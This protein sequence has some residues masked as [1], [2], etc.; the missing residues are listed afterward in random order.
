LGL[1]QTAFL[2]YNI[3]LINTD[4]DLNK[5]VKAEV[6]FLI[7]RQNEIVILSVDAEKDQE[8]IDYIIK[9]VLNYVKVNKNVEH[10][11]YLMPL[12]IAKDNH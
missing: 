6:A 10:K 3:L 2:F 1:N 8:N 7:N 9:D 12:R 4:L 11:K 5:E